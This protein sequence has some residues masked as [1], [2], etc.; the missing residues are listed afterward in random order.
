MSL[1]F[2]K[3][4]NGLDSKS[5]YNLAPAYLSNLL[6]TSP[7]PSQTAATVLLFYLKRAVLVLP[8][9]LCIFCFSSLEHDSPDS[10]LSG[11]IFTFKS[12][13]RR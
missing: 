2:L 8:Q 1:I 9:G 13:I 5:S 7:T 11:S 10:L 12:Q 4:S 3:P 6:P